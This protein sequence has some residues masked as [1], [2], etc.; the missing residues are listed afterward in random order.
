LQAEIDN[1]AIADKIKKLEDPISH[2]HENI[3]DVS[4]LI[5]D[6]LINSDLPEI[7]FKPEIFPLT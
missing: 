1:A 4:R 2:L 3:P 6:E 7:T 5:Y